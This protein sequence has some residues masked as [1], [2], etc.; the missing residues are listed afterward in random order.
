LRHGHIYVASE[1]VL[2]FGC[3]PS[4]SIAQCFAHLVRQIVSERM[5]A[6]DVPFVADL[7]PRAGPHLCAW[8][9]HRDAL[10]A[11]TGREQALLFHI[12]I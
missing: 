1:L 8:F 2:G 9:A 5:I 10:T 3:A 6:E 4:S 12:S 7:C 11:E